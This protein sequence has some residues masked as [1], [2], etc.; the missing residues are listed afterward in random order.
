METRIVCS[1]VEMQLKNSFVRNSFT[2]LHLYVSSYAVQKRTLFNSSI[3]L[4]S[5]KQRK[6]DRKI[7]R[8]DYTL[9]YYII[10]T[11]IQYQHENLTKIYIKKISVQHNCSISFRKYFHLVFFSFLSTHFLAL[12]SE[13]Q[14][15]PGET[16]AEG[17]HNKYTLDAVV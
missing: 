3:C 6:E 7:S 17:K 14:Q 5:G 2:H 13:L 12:Y 9:H 15:N 16:K 11:L 10:I 4:L 1:I 8:R